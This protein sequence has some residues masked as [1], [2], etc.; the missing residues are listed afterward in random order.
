M[1]ILF[2]ID[3]T[4]LDTKPF[5]KHVFGQVLQV[6]ERETSLD[7]REFSRIKEAYYQMLPESTDFD[8]E[9]FIA[10]LVA[11]TDSLIS[12]AMQE[13]LVNF[14]YEK[15]T[16]T[17]FLYED[18]LR[19]LTRLSVGNNLGIYSQGSKKY[20]LKKIEN[21]GISSFFEQKYMYTFKRKETPEAIEQVLSE[22]GPDHCFIDDRF[23]FVDALLSHTAQPVFL[24]QRTPQLADVIFSKEMLSNCKIVTSLDEVLVD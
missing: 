7:E 23:C 19:N 5:A 9:D 21:S 12:T 18:V 20:Q 15:N 2:D 13:R 16:L 11:E 1:V 22:V 3:N 14:F 6:L 10:F 8:P 24:L 17:S 4:L